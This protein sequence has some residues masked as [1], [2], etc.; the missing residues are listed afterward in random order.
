[1]TNMR[2]IRIEKITLNVGAG[3]DQSLLEKGMKL[4]KNITGIDPV[5][6]VTNKR[7]PS[8][9]VRPGLPIGTKLTIR[10]KNKVND[11]VSRFLKAKE[12]KLKSSCFDKNGNVSFGIHEYID[13]PGL[14]YDPE[15]GIIGFQICIT[16]ERP[17]FSLKRKSLNKKPIGK[18]H[19]IS[20]DDSI[21]FMKNEFKIEVEQ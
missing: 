7:I 17:G 2:D 21:S 16:L 20:Q 5:K 13:I 3:K 19:L 12:N 11:L 9:G 4:L 14:E 10:D 8:W 6:T 18:K 1:M 15:I